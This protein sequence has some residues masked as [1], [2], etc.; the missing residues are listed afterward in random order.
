[1]AL[2]DERGFE[3]VTIA[4]IAAAADI[5]PR[6]FFAYFPSKEDVVFHDF[7]VMFEAIKQRIDERAEG[8]TTMDALRAFVESLFA[9]MDHQDPAEQCRR[10]V[11]SASPSLQQH[12]RELVGRIENVIA[13]GLGARSRRRAGQLARPRGRGR[14]GRR[15][16]R[17][18]AVLRQGASARGSDGD[19]RR[20]LHVRAR[21]RRGA[22]AP[23]AAGLTRRFASVLVVSATINVT[24][25]SDPGCPWAY[26]AAPH[27]AVLHWRYGAQLDWRLTLIGLTETAAAYDARG[28]KPVSGARGYLNFRRF[29]MPFDT[30]P[31]ERN[32]ATG[33]ACRAVVAARLLD[34]AAE[35][36]VFRALQL[37]RFTTTTLFDTDEG[38]RAAL[39]RVPQVDAGAVV[40]AIGDPATEAAYQ[41]DRAAARTASGS[42]TEFQGKAANTD[43]AVRY[44]APSLI[45][46][47]RDG[48][49]LEAG[50]FQPVEAYDVVIANLDATLDRRPPGEDVTEI[51][52]AFP[53]ALT[54]H[55]V[56][57][58]MAPHLTPPD[59][60]AAETA[61]IEAAGE[62]ALRRET[63]GG[64]ELWH[65]A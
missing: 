16:D 17:A 7:G 40:A 21:R 1:M 47:H 24:H 58:V 41:A 12:D 32:I 49:R 63:I 15:A 23:S 20:G 13:D 2:F 48:R 64:G 10:R 34:P 36:P 9:E 61:L 27:H 30:Q 3:R 6:T 54:T 38:I 14:G 29:G 18:R 50:G 59:D 11:I 35:L 65:L 8:E 45:F 31:R 60:R 43:G 4:D 39:A 52:R 19:L 25:V 57:A 37:A 28:Y 53:Y 42:P 56:A 62:E 44:T 22:A 51:L 5:A 55:E 33:R 46:E 26:S